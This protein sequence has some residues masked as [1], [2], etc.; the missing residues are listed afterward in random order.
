MAEPAAKAGWNIET[1]FAVAPVEGPPRNFFAFYEGE[2]FGAS[3]RGTLAVIARG[4]AVEAEA[5]RAAQDA[6]QIAVHEFA[7]GYFGARSTLSPKRAAAKAMASVNRWL[8]GQG[9]APPPPVSLSALLLRGRR[10]GL[11]QL[12]T[13]QM[14]RLRQGALTP[15][16]APHIRPAASEALPARALGLSPELPLDIGE[17]EAEPGDQFLLIAGLAGQEGVLSTLAQ[18]I[19]S[20]SLAAAALAALAALPAP[21]KAVMA[22][23][24]NALPETVPDPPALVSLAA[25]PIRPPPRAGDVWDDF[26][27]GSVLF[28]GRYTML[29]AAYDRLCQREVA[30]KLPL[31]SMLQDEVFAAGFMR[32]AWIGAAV[33]SPHVAQYIDIPA[34]RR[35]ALYLAMPLYKGET[36][37][38]RLGRAPPLSLPEGMGIAFRLCEA[39]R[40]L[41]AIDVVHRDIKPENVMLLESGEIKLL[42]LG[43]AYLPGIETASAGGSGGTIRYM[44]PELLKGAPASSRTEVYA[45]AVTLYRMFSGGAFPFG[46]HERYPLQR[47]RPDLPPWLGEALGR[48]L[49]TRTEERFADAEELAHALRAGLE[50]GRDGAAPRPARLGVRF[51]RTLALL[52]AA[53]FFLTL[54][55]ALI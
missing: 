3:D 36:L 44:A 5:A 55:W 12:G 16:M 40:D 7:E 54:A 34:S 48:G 10:I 29:V 20:P 46:Q 32:E 47:L 1:E 19:H 25:L 30:L 21:D 45:L 31:P 38:R 33:H 28:R 37:E 24:L 6:A 15:L 9:K 51:W 26:V 11:V 41:A 39:V 14:Y 18:A 4:H 27:I 49:A 2:S 22:L 42:D 23:R 35:T 50:G 17:E 43:L 52:F 53:L 8:A 13:C